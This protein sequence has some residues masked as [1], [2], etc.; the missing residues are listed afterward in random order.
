MRDLWWPSIALL[1]LS[2][3]EMHMLGNSGLT[4]TSLVQRCAN[5]KSAPVTSL[6]R[7]CPPQT[8]T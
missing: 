1:V 7:I 4:I 3:L 5:E 8:R 6:E 2:G